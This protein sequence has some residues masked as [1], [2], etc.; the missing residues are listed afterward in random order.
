MPYRLGH[1]RSKD[2]KTGKYIILLTDHFEWSAKTN[3]LLY[4]ERW[5]IELFFKTFKPK[6]KIK[7][8]VGTLKN[9]QLS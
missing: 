1:L 5:Q 9:A 4:K 2:P 3:A 8:F 7:S 6:L